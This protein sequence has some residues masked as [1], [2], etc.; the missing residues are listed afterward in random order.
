MHP[1]LFDFGGFQIYS[2]GAMVALAFLAGLALIIRRARTV[3]DDES[4]YLEGM[5][6][7][8]IAGIV[9]ARLFYF[10]WYPDRF[11]ADPLG[12]L[13][14]QGGLVWYGGMVGVSLA[15]ILFARL[16]KLQLWRAAD[17]IIP[18]AALG[19]AIGRI[20]CLLAGCCYGGPTTLPWAIHYPHTHETQG[21]AVHP[22][23]VYESLLLL[24][25]TAVLLKIDKNKSFDGLTTWMFFIIY[26]VVRFILEY[27][28]GDRLIWLDALNLSASQLISLGGIALGLLMIAIL[29]RTPRQ[30]SGQTA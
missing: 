26:G 29:S 3:G 22:T 5:T 19:L 10:I 20:G 7:F 12:T 9:G 16:K 21:L 18:G 4:L 25:V 28:R 17:V 8:I 15:V 11:L 1:V 13:F 30:H 14:S 27:F 2:F 6:W 23:P 24:I